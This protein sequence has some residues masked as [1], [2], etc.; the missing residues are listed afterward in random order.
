MH[1]EVLREGEGGAEKEKRR[2]GGK[3]RRGTKGKAGN[4]EMV[5]RGS[6]TSNNSWSEVNEDDSRGT[7]WDRPLVGPFGAQTDIASE[8]ADHSKLSARVPRRRWRDAT[9]EEKVKMHIRRVVDSQVKERGNDD[10]SSGCRWE[11]Q[12][13]QQG[14][15][16]D[17]D[18]VF[19]SPDVQRDGDHA[20]VCDL[21]LGIQDQVRTRPCTRLCTCRQQVSDDV[22]AEAFA[23]E[24]AVGVS[25]CAF[26]H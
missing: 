13:P 5:E 25:H 16:T 10:A 4:G 1:Q 9:E 8:A 15:A 7:W 20:S 22:S 26:F 21:L 23:G 14:S 12:Q 17:S 3:A 2:V 11:E 6:E 18:R 19:S 24:G